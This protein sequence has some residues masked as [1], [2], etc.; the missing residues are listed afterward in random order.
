V[1]AVTGEFLGFALSSDGSKI[2]AGTKEDG[3][4]V[5][6][7]S[8]LVFNKVASIAVQC[9][10]THGQELW[11]CSDSATTS[12]YLSNEFVVGVTTDDGAHFTRKMKTISSICGA[13]S[14]PAG[15]S[16]SL[17]CNAT[18]AGGQCQQSFTDFCGLNDLTGAC[19]TCGADAGA[20]D[21]G[22]PDATAIA[23]AGAADAGTAAAS[24]SASSSCSCDAA[25]AGGGEVAGF[26]AVALLA[27]LA[28]GR[29]RKQT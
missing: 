20:P 8:D 14:C 29:R 28:R 26:G 9:L 1:Y 2:Y 23:D 15:A 12:K 18:V 10:A 27:G 6:N 7:R 5:A 19:G 3:L 21:A 13:L 17:G 16:T 25:G 22:A 11:V 24:A 4:F